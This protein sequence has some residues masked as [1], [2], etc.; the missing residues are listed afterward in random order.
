MAATNDMSNPSDKDKTKIINSCQ[1]CFNPL[2][3]DAIKASHKNEKKA[4]IL[5][6]K[7]SNQNKDGLLIKI[8]LIK[9][10]LI[11]VEN[12]SLLRLRLC[13]FFPN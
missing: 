11:K 2:I 3:P 13:F 7:D 1:Y 8:K 10:K 4:N 5:I 9:S 6:K 12:K